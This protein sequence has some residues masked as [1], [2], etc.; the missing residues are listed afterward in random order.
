VVLDNNPAS[1]L[2]RNR[3][4]FQ[5][6]YAIFLDRVPL[7]IPSVKK[8]DGR[9]IRVGDVV[10]FVFQDSNNN[11]NNNNKSFIFPQIRVTMT[12]IEFLRSG[13][14]EYSVHEHAS[15]NSLG[16]GSVP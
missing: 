16:R 9:E 4:I 5:K 3:L 7:L 1:Q 10:L 11:N 12:G 2:E 15:V 14:T 13:F 6:W 8:E